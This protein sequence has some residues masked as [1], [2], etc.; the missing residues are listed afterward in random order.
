MFGVCGWD[1]GSAALCQRRLLIEAAVRSRGSI[2]FVGENDAHGKPVARQLFFVDA[3][4]PDP[5]KD[6]EDGTPKKWLY[7][8]IGERR[9][10]M[11]VPLFA[12]FG[13]AGKC[14]MHHI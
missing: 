9:G 4:N 11:R 1:V 13:G 3:S 12:S 2:S 5:L 10:L 8:Y 14:C 7:Y 6:P